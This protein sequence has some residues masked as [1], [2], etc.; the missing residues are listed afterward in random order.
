MAHG[1]WQ[2]TDS[3]RAEIRQRALALTRTARNLLLIL[4]AS[5]PA[6]DWIALVNGATPTDFAGLADQ[7]LVEPVGGAPA[8]VPAAEPGAFDELRSALM[9]LDYESLYNL[10]TAQVREQM[11]LIKGYRMA[12]EIER[13]AGLPELQALALRLAAQWHDELRLDGLRKALQRRP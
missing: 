1:R 4:D 5:K 12:L 3:G 9:A 6:D 7:G 11:G 13:C 2:K 8:A 10:L